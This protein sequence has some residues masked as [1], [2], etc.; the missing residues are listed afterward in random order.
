[1]KFVDIHTH[2]KADDQIIQLINHPVQSDFPLKAG[3]NYSVGIHPWDIEH[4]DSKVLLSR[5][6]GIAQERQVRAIGECGLDRAIKT[7][8]EKQSQIF[9]RQI[10]IAEQVQKPLIIHAVKTYSELIQLKKKRGSS[11]PWILHGYQGNKQTTVQLVNHD[12]YFSIG[13]KILLKSTKHIESIK[14]IPLEKLFFE[15]DDSSEKVETIYT[16]A[17]QFL[18]VPLNELQELIFNNYQRIFGNG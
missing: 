5:L 1:M 2:Q 6:E 15:T 4:F 16:F 8:L 14:Q 17:S 12:F 18:D 3:A 13:T 9:I 11:L 10:E 7:P